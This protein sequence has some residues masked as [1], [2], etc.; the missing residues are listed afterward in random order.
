MSTAWVQAFTGWAHDIRNRELR[1]KQ[2]DY[3]AEFSLR[4]MKPPFDLVR[5][6][7]DLLQAGFKKWVSGLT[8]EELENFS[9]RVEKDFNEFQDKRDK[10]KN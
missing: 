7:Q 4:G 5:K 2:A 1:A 10:G 6:E 9:D 3:S 8:T